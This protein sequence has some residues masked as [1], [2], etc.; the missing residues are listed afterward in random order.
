MREFLERLPIFNRELN[1]PQ[2][3]SKPHGDAI[4][5]ESYQQSARERSAVHRVSGT[6][7]L[8]CL[9]LAG[10]SKSGERGFF[11][12]SVFLCYKNA[13]TALMHGGFSTIISAVRLE[14]L[15]LNNLCTQYEEI[16]TLASSI[17]C[18]HSV[19]GEEC[20]HV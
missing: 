16:M 6:A 7:Q 1:H 19:M 11:Y 4:G 10:S 20:F 2:F 8:R 3:G 9:T 5:L 15:Y 18:T 14:A 17:S 13:E 12:F